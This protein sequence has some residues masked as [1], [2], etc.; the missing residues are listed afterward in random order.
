LSEDLQFC[1]LYLFLLHPT[2]PFKKTDKNT[3]TPNEN[4]AKIAL[5]QTFAKKNAKPHI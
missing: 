1:G 2:R 4:H 3:P 5:C